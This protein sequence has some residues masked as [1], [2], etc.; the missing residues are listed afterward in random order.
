MEQKS[1]WIWYPGD[2]EIY[3]ILQ[4]NLRREERGYGRPAFWKQHSPHINVKFRKKFSCSGGYMKAFFQGSGYIALDGVRHCQQEQIPIPEGNHTVEVLLSNFGGLPAVYLQS[5]VCP[6]DSTWECDCFLG[7]FV[8]VGFHPHFDSAEQDP[9]VF[10]FVYERKMPVEI[11]ALPE[12]LLY[13]FG[14]ELFGCLLIFNADPAVQLGIFYG[15]SREEALDTGHSYLTDSLQ[16]QR[17]Y[18]LKQ[19]AFRYVYITSATRALEVAMDYEYLPLTQRGTFSCSNPLFN[20]IYTAAVH[21]FH[22]NCREGFLDGIKR[23]RWIWS[24][25][26][27]QSAKINAYLFYDKDIVERTAIGLAGRAPVTQHLNTILDYSMLWII[28]LYEHYM[29]YGDL[30]FLQRIYPTAESML[31]LCQTRINRDGFI[32]GFPNDWTFIDW[33]DIDKT[34][35]VCAEQML[36]IASYNTMG[37][38]AEALGQDGTGYFAMARELQEQVNRHYWNGTLGGFIDSYTSGKNHLTRHANIFAV[39]Y[40]IATEEQ[41]QSILHNVLLNSRVPQITTPYF[42]GYELDVLAK[43]GQFASVEAALESYWGGMLKL[44]AKTIWEEFDPGQTGI[45]HYAMYDDKYDKSLCHAWG[46]GP[47]YLFGRYYLGVSPTAPGYETFTVAPQAGGLS[48]FRGTVPVGDGTVTVALDSS[49]L[50]VTATKPGGTLLWQ[51]KAYPLTENLP[52]ILPAY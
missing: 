18:R 9:Q 4:A 48:A 6:S 8:P 2:Y 38:I 16:G 17:S 19:R 23:D 24:G 35:A 26:A 32:E 49:R 14:T 1:Y 22:L 12:G 21:T 44:G 27:Y 45:R 40:G 31:A 25:D 5:D 42:R 46:A 41:I 11:T 34:G 13:D 7:E 43:L 3:H 15:E 10:P 52:V 28:G 47:V 30:S 36:L 37:R 20:D 33:S 39:M 50:E 51:G 29:T